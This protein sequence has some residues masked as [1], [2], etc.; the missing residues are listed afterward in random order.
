ME[1]DVQGRTMAGALC[2]DAPRPVSVVT[3]VDEDI[4]TP[5][6]PQSQQDQQQQQPQT[7]QSPVN[8]QRVRSFA[9]A[10]AQTDGD[11]SSRLA[12][13][14]EAVED[15]RDVRRRERRPRRHRR[16][17]R[18]CSVPPSYPAVPSCIASAAA[19]GV[20]LV[21]PAA[22]GFLHPPPPHLGLRGLSLGLPFPVPASVSA[23]GRLVLFIFHFLYGKL[24]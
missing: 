12:S 8:V 4:V 9:S 20:P 3:V 22:G 14:Q 1:T 24:L 15:A 18:T 7:H 6:N 16:P 2:E 10:E 21:S 13:L 19:T 5:A 17:L 11:L 23:F